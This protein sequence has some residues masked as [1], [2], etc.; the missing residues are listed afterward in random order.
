MLV[1][2]STLINV[3]GNIVRVIKPQYKN[4]GTTFNSGSHPSKSIPLPSR[5]PSV[6]II[7]AQNDVIVYKMDMYVAISIFLF[8]YHR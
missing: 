8:L 1:N 6:T 3:N 5:C 2:L 7:A 4:V